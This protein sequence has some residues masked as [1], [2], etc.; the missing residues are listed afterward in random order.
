MNEMAASVA[1]RSSKAGIGTMIQAWGAGHLTYVQDIAKNGAIQS[2]ASISL[3]DYQATLGETKV[4]REIGAEI[5]II[6][7]R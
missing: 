5:D 2:S 6:L 4:G 7:D 3:S 1:P